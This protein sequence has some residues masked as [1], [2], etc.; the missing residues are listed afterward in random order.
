MLK[1]NRKE[2]RRLWDPVI[3]S[4]VPHIASIYFVTGCSS[5]DYLGLYV[6]YCIVIGGSSLL[7]FI[8]HTYREPKNIWFCLDYAFAFIW[9][10]Y[11]IVIS[12]IVASNSIVVIVILLNGVCIITNHLTDCI[13]KRGICSYEVSHSL[14]HIINVI[15]SIIVAYLISCHFQ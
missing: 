12:S 4:T 9:T 2:I 8:W 10:G 11:D 7:S 15:K 1:I 3:L 5:P 6:G 14:W 13:A